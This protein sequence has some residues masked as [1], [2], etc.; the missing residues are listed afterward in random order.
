M[1]KFSVYG[2]RK[3]KRNMVSPFSVVVEAPDRLYAKAE[4]QIL[5]EYRGDREIIPIFVFEAE[6]ETQE[7]R[8]S[9]RD[10]CAIV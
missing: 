8:S 10:M 3:T 7:Q 9:R 5:L 6:H 1:A 4:A 2:V